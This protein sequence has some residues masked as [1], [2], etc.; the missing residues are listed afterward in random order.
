MGEGG[1]A[2]RRPAHAASMPG[3]A[4]SGPNKNAGAAAIRTAAG[5]VRL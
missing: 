4:S 5:C 2:A 3:A 1:V